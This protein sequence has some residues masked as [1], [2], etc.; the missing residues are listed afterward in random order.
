MSQGQSQSNNFEVG[1]TVLRKVIGWYARHGC[2][3]NKNTEN[4]SCDM[5][6]SW[7]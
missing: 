1:E 7:D 6:V 3:Y 5:G 2:I 4:M